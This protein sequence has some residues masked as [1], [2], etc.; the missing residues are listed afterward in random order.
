MLYIIYLFIPTHI[1]MYVLLYS[2]VLLWILYSPETIPIR[3]YCSGFIRML[4]L[5]AGRLSLKDI[6]IRDLNLG[7]E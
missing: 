1:M 5:S 7:Y 6:R 2:N 3:G 4:P